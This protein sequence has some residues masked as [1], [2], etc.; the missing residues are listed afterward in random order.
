MCTT[1]SLPYGGGGLCPG[2]FLS[3]RPSTHCGQTDT[4]DN[5]TFPQTSF[6]SG[7]NTNFKLTFCHKAWFQGKKG[8]TFIRNFTNTMD[9]VS[10]M[11]L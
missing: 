5:I 8:T 4:C 2:G 10:K 7:K 9:L 6:T 1:R 3:G 11:E